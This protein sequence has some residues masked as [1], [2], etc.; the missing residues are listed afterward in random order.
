MD[1]WLGVDR[2]RIRCVVF[3]AVGTLI[4]ATPAVAD[5][6]QAIGSQ[7]NSQLGR[8]EIKQRFSNAFQQVELA[9]TMIGDVHATNES[10][11]RERW[12]EIVG[13][14][15]PDVTD[16]ESCFNE[17]WD[18]FG[19]PRSWRC[20]EDVPIVRQLHEAGLQVTIAS[21]FDSRLNSVCDGMPE[22]AWV[23]TRVISSEVGFQKPSHQFFEALL[24]TVNRHP[25]EVLFVGD[26][27]ENDVMGPKQAGINAIHL[28]RQH[29][30]NK[31]L[32]TDSIA[33][34][35]ELV[36]LL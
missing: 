32:A 17:L 34:L 30:L 4:E 22:L 2:S 10:A 12:R 5:A 20:F 21:N 3:D 16:P 19:R 25:H 26:D 7:Y 8:D 24:T 33:S 28:N 15:L 29:E 13:R 23:E 35:R 27:L 9:P 18:H 14:V 31:P 36:A 1:D 6:Y 11:E